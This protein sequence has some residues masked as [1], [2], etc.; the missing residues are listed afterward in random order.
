MKRIVYI[1]LFW[2][3]NLFSTTFLFAQTVTLPD[4]LNGGILDTILVEGNQH[5]AEMSLIVHRFISTQDLFPQKL[6]NQIPLDFTDLLQR[7]SPVQVNVYGNGNIATLSYRGANEDQTKISWNGILLNSATLGGSDL[8]L[9]TPEAASAIKIESYSNSIGGAMKL[10]TTPDWK[11]K[12]YTSFHADIGSF[13]AYKNAIQLKI[14]NRLVQFH[15]SGQY[16]TAKNNYPYYDI[17]KEGKPLDTLSHNEL[18]AWSTVN[19]FFLKIPREGMLSFGNWLFAKEKQLPPLMGDFAESNKY[20]EDMNS[21]T[22]LKYSG[23]P[24][25]NF[26]MEFQVSHA[27]EV[28]DYRDKFLPSD[29]FY[30][31]NTQDKI[32]RFSQQF[33]AKKTIPRLNLQIN[34]GTDYSF[35]HAAV[36]QYANPVKEHRGSIF[37][38]I[39]YQKGFLES[40]LKIEQPFTS[41]KVIRPQFCAHLA[42]VDFRKIY[43]LKFTYKDMYRFPDLNDR[44]WNPGGNPDLKDE[45]GWNL[46]LTNQLH[47]KKNKKYYLDFSTTIYLAQIT[48]NIVWLP[49]NAVI[50]TPRNI[51]SV[52]RYG[53]ENSLEISVSPIDKFTWNFNGAYLFNRTQIL[54]DETNPDLKNKYL[55]YRPQHTFKLNTDFDFHFFSLGMN[56]VYTS[57]RFTDKENYSFFALK[58]YHLLNMF[59]K[60]SGT[61]KNVSGAFVFKINNLTNT[62]YESV[63]AYAQPLRNFSVSIILSFQNKLKNENVQ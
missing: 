7:Y 11:N 38:H 42:L 35:I 58:S 46:E 13:D 48:N 51:A 62:A 15:L 52:R 26:Y 25:R 53:L 6:M 12:I 27:N 1:I 22:Y 37:G 40:G 54:K 20:Q 39:Y 60:F 59:L 36:P 9:I 63:R 45:S 34:V 50:W 33:L 23:I 14:G 41:Y 29:T 8:S 10:S 28:L 61:Y 19:E 55:A 18:K 30:F 24:L 21:R 47:C 2:G 31:I 44:Y 57:T 32:V 16:Q 56:Y 5:V 49:V 43:V 3:W 4:T 17:Y